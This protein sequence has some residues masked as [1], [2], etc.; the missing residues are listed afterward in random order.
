MFWE[1]LSVGR[2]ELHCF[3][4]LS[5]SFDVNILASPGDRLC[6]VWHYPP[7]TPTMNEA[8]MDIHLT[9]N[10]APLAF[11][12]LFPLLSVICNITLLLLK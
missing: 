8:R 4:R 5:N 12:N 11:F 7:M 2:Y 6:G 9:F 3:P 10:P 1:A